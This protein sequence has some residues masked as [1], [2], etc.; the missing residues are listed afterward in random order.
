VT[1]DHK[2][3]NLPTIL[4]GKMPADSQVIFCATLHATGSIF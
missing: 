2:N 3:I 4:D 1:S